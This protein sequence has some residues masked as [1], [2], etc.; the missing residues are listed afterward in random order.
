M[1]QSEIR[2]FYN[3]IHKKTTKLIK[4]LNTRPDTINLLEVKIGRILPDINC[5]NIFSDL[6]LTIIKIKA[7]INKWDLI[8]LKFFSQ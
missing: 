7:K 2:I 1:K 6:P 5:K 3:T 8:K 4:Y